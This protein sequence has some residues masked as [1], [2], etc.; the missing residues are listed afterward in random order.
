MR[1]LI[2][3]RL[4]FAILTL[5]QLSVIIFLLTRV[6]PGDPARLILGPMA[7]QSSVDALNHE[8]GTDQ[9]LLQQYWR[10]MSG[11]LTGDL[12]TSFAYNTSVNDLIGNAFVRSLKLALVSFA[13]MVPAAIL[14]GVVAALKR[15][16][17]TD[18]VITMGGLA[19][20]VIPEF[21]T[22]IVLIIVFG[23]TLGLLPV[24]AN[25]PAG[26][27]PLVEL[28]YL[29]LPA[30]TIVAY[31]FGYVARITRASTIESLEAD[32]V[33]TAFLKGLPRSTVLRRH[34]L[35]NSLVPTIA[36][37]TVQ[38]GYALGSLVIVETLFNYPGLG[39][40][41][42]D[43]ATQQDFPLLAGSVMVVATCFVLLTLAADL[44]YTMMSPRIRY[45]AT[46]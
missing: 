9:P 31:L 40:L 2:L 1:R 32:Y 39:R 35:R 25:A 44:L 42:F 13:I 23:L 43:A 3:R 7:D 14:G 22:G 24:D 20:S 36:V 27:G 15:D 45:G 11:V 34:V 37:V 33:R 41:I 4:L 28:K 19:L 26:S 38:A 16:K 17:V 18:R 8:L 5:L 29:L 30:L 12:G 6:L 10:W 46:Q 21:V